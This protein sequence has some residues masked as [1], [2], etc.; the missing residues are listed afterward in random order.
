MTRIEKAILQEEEHQ[1][2]EQSK[3]RNALIFKIVATTVVVGIIVALIIHGY[4]RY[5]ETDGTSKS[6]S[7]QVGNIVEQPN[8]KKEF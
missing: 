7:E 6:I 1:K 3:K 8:S 2:Q 5:L 4:L